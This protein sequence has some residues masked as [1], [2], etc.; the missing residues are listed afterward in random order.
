MTPTKKRGPR[1]GRAATPKFKS[2][3]NDNRPFRCP[4]PGPGGQLV[5]RWI[6]AAERF[7]SAF[8]RAQTDKLDPAVRAGLQP[9]F[10]A[11]L[12]L[13][14][15]CFPAHESKA[16]LQILI[17]CAES[18]LRPTPGIVLAL[19]K[20]L[21]WTIV[22]G[23]GDELAELTTLLECEASAAGLM[24]WATVLRNCSDR[25]TVAGVLRA[26]YPLVL[27]P[28]KPITSIVAY[29]NEALSPWR[30]EGVRHVA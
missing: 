10:D 27:D 25:C 13:D 15:A 26:A 28:S 21:G 7:L 18:G 16:L 17:G 24:S 19:A 8:Y 2:Q 11:D 4:P 22:T 29:L 9:A 14:S 12:Q 20:S 5:V 6:D 30:C 23:G 3:Q 1:P